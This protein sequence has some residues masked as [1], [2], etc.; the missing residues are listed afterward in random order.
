MVAYYTK[1]IDTFR[2]YFSGFL[3]KYHLIVQ[4]TIIVQDFNEVTGRSF[5]VHNSNNNNNIIRYA[6]YVYNIIL[7]S[8]LHNIQSIIT[9]S[10]L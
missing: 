4:N 5:I 7:S 1:Y 6:Q 10:S 2:D 9:V 8:Y 3:L